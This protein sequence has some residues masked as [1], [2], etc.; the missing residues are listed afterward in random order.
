M[1]D[2]YISAVQMYSYKFEYMMPAGEIF[3]LEF[4]ELSQGLDE[5]P[6]KA[7]YKQINLQP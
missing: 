2:A 3:D 6:G 5:E 4:P 1:P 7:K